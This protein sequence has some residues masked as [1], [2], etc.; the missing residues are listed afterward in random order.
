MRPWMGWAWSR[1]RGP[2]RSRPRNS[3]SPLPTI[4]DAS[5]VVLNFPGLSDLPLKLRAQRSRYGHVG[6]LGKMLAKRP[7]H[8]LVGAPRSHQRKHPGGA[9]V[10]AMV[11]RH[12]GLLPALNL[13]VALGH[14]HGMVAPRIS[15]ALA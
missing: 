2:R 1:G 10:Q 9:H 8:A 4:A 6:L 14:G 5:Q 15:G 7:R 12:V 3:V 11:N 13:Q